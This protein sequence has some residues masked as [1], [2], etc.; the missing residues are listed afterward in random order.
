MESR[1]KMA[2]EAAA[3]APRALNVALGKPTQLDS[4]KVATDASSF[5]S[6]GGGR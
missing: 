2:P 4:R 5:D 6:I 1:K 3:T